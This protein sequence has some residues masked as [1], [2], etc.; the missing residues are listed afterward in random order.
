MQTSRNTWI[1]VAATVAAVLVLSSTLFVSSGSPTG[2]EGRD[3]VLLRCNTNDAAFSATGYKGSA[4]TPS[5]RSDNCAENVSQLM[6]DGFSIRD[7]GHY[8]MEKAGYT[9]ITMVR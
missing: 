7:I 5:K 4:G 3:V 9:V 6:K 1:L 2:K 8:D